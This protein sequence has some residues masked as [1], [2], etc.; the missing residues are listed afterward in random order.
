MHRYGQYTGPAKYLLVVLQLYTGIPCREWLVGIN[1][2]KLG[3]A[4]H[5]LRCSIYDDRRSRKW[6]VRGLKRN[7]RYREREKNNMSTH[8]QVSTI[9]KSKN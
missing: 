5:A 8:V 7:H 9:R 4:N 6:L 2:Y 1:L 3:V